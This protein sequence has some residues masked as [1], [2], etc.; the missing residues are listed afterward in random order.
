[1]KQW[2]KDGVA[3]VARQL[4]KGEP[5]RVGPGFPLAVFAAVPDRR[6]DILSY[7]ERFRRGVDPYQVVASCIPAARPSPAPRES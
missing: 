4:A 6:P 1:M 5:H 7:I 3:E 2:V